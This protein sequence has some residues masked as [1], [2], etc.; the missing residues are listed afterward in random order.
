MYPYAAILQVSAWLGAAG[1]EQGR[2]G[3]SN[4]EIRGKRKAAA[5][6]G[7]ARD[8]WRGEPVGSRV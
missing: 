6:V 8:E 3:E 4:S 2:G 5:A 7:Q 1:R